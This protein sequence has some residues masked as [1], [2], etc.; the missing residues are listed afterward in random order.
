MKIVTVLQPW[1]TLLALGIKQYETRSWKTNHRGLIAIHAAKKRNRHLD[2][3]TREMLLCD[4]LPANYTPDNLPRGKVVGVAHLTKVEK[5]EDVIVTE[6]ERM[7][8]DWEPGRYVWQMQHAHLFDKP[9]PARGKQGLW[10][11]DYPH[12]KDDPT[13]FLCYDTGYEYDRECLVPCPCRLTEAD[14]KLLAK[15]NQTPLL[16]AEFVREIRLSP[17][18]GLMM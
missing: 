5:A 1:A 16:R 6:K 17:Y 12:E 13:C 7:L 15:I 18:S 11:W 9:I 10:N 14:A 4:V 8:G 2:A 3:L